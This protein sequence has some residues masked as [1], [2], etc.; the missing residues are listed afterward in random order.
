[1]THTQTYLAEVEEIAKGLDHEAIEKMALGL[2]KITGRVFCVGLG[3]SLANAIHMAA[4]FRKLCRIDAE[5]VSNI[6]EIT[7]RANDEGLSTIFSGIRFNE[8]D[9]LFILSVGGGT[10]EV[11]SAIPQVIAKALGARTKIFGIV[12]PEG[13][14]TWQN[15]HY[16]VKVPAKERVTPHTESFQAVI[17]HLLV[18]H[19]I[20]QKDPTKW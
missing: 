3:G 20:L 12:G 7:A 17:W 19:P 9:A 11:S 10:P 4:D 2:S 14:Y 6:A 5:A 15:A 8:G 16:C 13:R 18:S 1:M